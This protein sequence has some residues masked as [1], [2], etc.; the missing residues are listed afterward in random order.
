MSRIYFDPAAS[1][2]CQPLYINK[3]PQEVVRPRP[4]TLLTHII[5]PLQS[6]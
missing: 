5:Y 6:L 3:D 1:Q 4:S 2:P